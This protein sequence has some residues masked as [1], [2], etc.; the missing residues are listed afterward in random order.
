[1]V[2]AGLRSALTTARG[3]ETVR[4]VATYVMGV[5]LAVLG[6]PICLSFAA[7]GRAS[8]WS[9]AMLRGAVT[10]AAGMFLLTAMWWPQALGTIAL[11]IAAPGVVIGA[12][13]GAAGHGLGRILG[14]R[15]HVAAT[16]VGALL[17]MAALGHHVINPVAEQDVPWPDSG[18]TVRVQ[19]RNLQSATYVLR[20]DTAAGSLSMPLW[21]NWGPARR[22]NLYRTP[23]GSIAV[24][25]AGDYG[26]V[27]DLAPNGSPRHGQHGAITDASDWTYIG[28][29]LDQAWGELA[30]ASATAL[31]ECIPLY[32]EGRAPPG[33]GAWSRDDCD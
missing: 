1:M 21:N 3:C 5:V 29:V 13:F 26:W 9:M 6:L 22:I 15:G 18:V 32:G 27:I 33:R 8:G 17:C 30:F 7:G 23:A 14:A 10:G 31:P 24:A 19:Q 20:V 12:M 4:P 16:C 25:G 28:A 2:W 11:M